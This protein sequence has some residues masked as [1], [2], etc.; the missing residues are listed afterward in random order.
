MNSDARKDLR[1][2]KEW[3]LTVSVN[4]QNVTATAA[5]PALPA[6][7]KCFT[8]LLGD[9]VPGSAPHRLRLGRLTGCLLCDLKVEQDSQLS[10]D[11]LAA[12]SPASSSLP[13]DAFTSSSAGASSPAPESPSV[14]P[15][16]FTPSPASTPAHQFVHS[17]AYED[18]LQLIVDKE[19]VQPHDVFVV[20]ATMT[21]LKRT[22]AAQALHQ[23]KR[24]RFQQPSPGAPSAKRKSK[25]AVTVEMRGSP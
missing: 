7:P 10:K 22:A 25:L 16:A 5:L 2:L 1:E 24:Q 8:G 12:I 11:F 4:W 3:K 13:A 17:V 23:L 6:L 21:T 14:T 20:R 18:E 19:L 15:G 9:K